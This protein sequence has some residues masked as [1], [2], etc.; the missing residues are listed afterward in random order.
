MVNAASAPRLESGELQLRASRIRLM[1]TDVDGTLT[2]GGVYY[3][4]HGEE[5]KR[6]DLRDGMAVERLRT[7]G[8]E[9]AFITR[10][11]S[12][13]V[14]RRAEKLGV[15]LFA[16]LRDKHAALPEILRE[17]QVSA[18][19]TAYFG[20]DVNDLAVMEA[21]L[22]DGLAGAPADAQPQILERVHFRSARLGGHGA[23]REFAEWLIGL[24]HVKV[25][26]QE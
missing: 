20:D 21:V 13:L 7:C 8:V 9:T 4:E 2:D 10:E 6:F 14:Q 3:S 1:L 22:P 17:F 24:I 16:G 23:F 19:Q 5:L 15:K 11:S 25:S 18:Q 12:L 26:S